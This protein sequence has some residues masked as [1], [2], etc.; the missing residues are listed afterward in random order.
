ME[1]VSGT[2]NFITVISRFDI[3]SL[4]EKYYYYYSKVLLLSIQKFK[5]NYTKKIA[6]KKYSNEKILSVKTCSH[7][8]KCSGNEATSQLHRLGQFVCHCYPILLQ[9]GAHCCVILCM[10]NHIVEKV[11]HQPY[12]N[13]WW[14]AGRHGWLYLLYCARCRGNPQLR[15][16]LRGR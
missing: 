8:G 16:E 5:K 7:V 3:A 12:S 9:P 10:H 11:S 6:S 4:S 13:C 2:F 1:T 14:L 15:A